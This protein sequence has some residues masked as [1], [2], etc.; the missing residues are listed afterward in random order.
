MEMRSPLLSIEP[1]AGPEM[2]GKFL[3]ETFMGACRP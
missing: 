2:D 1:L 3:V